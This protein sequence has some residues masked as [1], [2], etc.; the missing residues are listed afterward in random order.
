MSH[1]RRQ[2]E[3]PVDRKILVESKREDRTIQIK[4]RVFIVTGASSG[5]GLATAIALSD[6]GAKVALLARSTDAL[7]KLAQQLPGSLP[8]TVDVT[9][10]D[11]VREAVS[12]V[13]K[14]YGRVD[15]LVNNA[16]RSYA[17]AIEEIDPALFDEIF[18]LNV[19]API[20]V[21][22][23]V[24]P[25]MRAQGGGSIVNINSGTSFM[26]VPQ[27]SVYSSS[28]RALLGFSLTAR[29][30]LEK[31]RI[32]VSEV[33]LFMMA[34]RNAQ[35]SRTM[36]EWATIHSIER[37]SMTAARRR[38]RSPR[39]KIGAGSYRSWRKGDWIVGQRGIT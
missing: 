36:S 29:A 32:V 22:Q 23:A 5:I 24:M 12:A 20:V 13:H 26:T 8:L 35:S 18:H 2:R 1:R 3:R 6:R 34:E 14:H 21:V 31:Y 10:F 27:Y 7:Q 39:A 33:Y 38:A 11:R 30:E 28:K 19:L 9:E 17:A 16:G 4:D 15:G 25:L 37:E